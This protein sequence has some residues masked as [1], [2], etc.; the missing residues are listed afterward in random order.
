MASRRNTG[1]AQAAQKRKRRHSN[2]RW[3]AK[4]RWQ[5]L[6]KAIKPLVSDE[7]LQRAFADAVYP[8]LLYRTPGQEWLHKAVSSFS[9]SQDCPDT[10][11]K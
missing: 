4:H 6:L 3:L 5:R 7:A 1:P 2:V 10:T 8:R 9:S 11:L